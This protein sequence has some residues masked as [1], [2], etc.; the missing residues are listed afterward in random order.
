M[1]KK[2]ILI[3]ALS[4]FLF[5]CATPTPIQEF[6]V[7]QAEQ[8]SITVTGTGEVKVA[9]DLAEVIFS[10][11]TANKDL[12]TAKEE[13]DEISRNVLEV[14]RKYKIEENDIKSD[15]LNIFPETSDST[16]EIYRY[17][18]KNGFKVTVRDLSILE[19]LITDVL[20]AGGNRI[21]GVYF[22]VSDLETQQ[23][24]ARELA[25]ESAKGKA[26]KMAGALGQEID[27]PLTITESPVIYP[28]GATSFL[29]LGRADYN[30]YN[31]EEFNVMA[32]G[33]ITIKASVSI[34]FSLK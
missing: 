10:V 6:Q 19:S 7:V 34:E 2:H 16:P 24:K 11:Y 22:R 13:N 15:Y 18:V 12:V 8:R 14:L 25:I 3:S 32:F 21:A 23:E 30:N 4:L 5:S 28:Y 31:F 17:G 27:M 26:I 29:A 20:K 9:P 33:Q 1:L